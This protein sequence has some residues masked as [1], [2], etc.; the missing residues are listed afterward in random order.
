MNGNPVE[1][2]DHAFAPGQV[3]IVMGGKEIR[4][5]AFAKIAGLV[6]KAGAD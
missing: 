1:P 3:T 6:P 5:E 2:F 4:A